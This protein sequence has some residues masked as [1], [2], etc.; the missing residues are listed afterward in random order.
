MRLIFAGMLIIAG[1]IGVGLSSIAAA[2]IV[3]SQRQYNDQWIIGTVPFVLGVLLIACGI[4][5]AWLERERLKMRGEDLAQLRK[6][7]A[8]RRQ[9]QAAKPPISSPLP[10]SNQPS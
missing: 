10:V 9:R 2:I 3:L 6:L 1:V 8:L 5:C 7:Q 4:G